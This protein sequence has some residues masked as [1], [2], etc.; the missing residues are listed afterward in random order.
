MP[1]CAPL[2]RTSPYSSSS[3]LFHSFHPFHLHP[4]HLRPYH[5]SLSHSP[6]TPLPT[7]RRQTRR[8]I[9]TNTHIILPFLLVFHNT[10]PS[11][12]HRPPGPGDFPTPITAFE[13]PFIDGIVTST[14]P[15]DTYKTH[16][17]ATSAGRIL[18]LS[19]RKESAKKGWDGRIN[20]PS[21]KQLL[22]IA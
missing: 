3:M 14:S 15:A 19:T 12:K 13:I 2:S 1:S 6:L 7:H 10:P 21:G 17:H 11:P 20:S 18:S 16:T 5:S 4:F 9:L 22:T 8:N